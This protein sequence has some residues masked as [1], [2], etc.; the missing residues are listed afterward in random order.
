MSLRGIK[1]SMSRFLSIVSIV[2]LGVGFLAGL[3]A[4][5]PDMKNSANKYFENSNLYDFYIQ[6]DIGFDEEDLK[7]IEKQSYVDKAMAVYQEDLIINDNNEEKLEARVFH[8]DMRKKNVINKVD[9]IDGRMPENENECLIEIPNKYGLKGELDETYEFPNEEKYKVVGIVRSPMFISSHSE[10]TNIGKGTITLGIYILPDKENKIFTTIYGRGNIKDR[11]TFKEEYK[12]DVSKIVT[13]LKT[14]ENSMI[15]E[16]YARIGRKTD[17]KEETIDYGKWHIFTRFNS[18]GIK[19]FS[20][21][22]E[23][24]EAIATVF[25]I[26]FF[27]VAALIVLT[28]MTRM[29]EEERTQVGVLKALGYTNGVIRN[30]YIIYGLIA[31]IIGSAIGLSVGF[32]LFPKVISNAYS[33]MY[34]LPKID[35]EFLWIIAI[36]IVISTLICVMS[37]IL[38]ACK[39]ELKEKPASLLQQKAPIPGKRIFLEKI[40]PLWKRLKFTRKVTL[41]NLFRYKKRF[42]MTVVGIAGCFSLL[43]AGFGVRDSI[44]NIDDLQFG[45]IFKHDIMISVKENKWKPDNK[46]FEE[47][48]T[49]FEKQIEVSNKDVK[50]KVT[51]EVPKE[52]ENLIDFV[53]LRERESKKPLVLRDDGV[54][55][56]EKVSE[57]LDIRVGD[58]VWIYNEDMKKAQVEVK[59]IFENYLDNKVFMTEDLYKKTFRET[60]GYNVVYAKLKKEITAKTE[61]DDIL[62]TIVKKTDVNYTIATKNIRN[63]FNDS[64]KNIDYIVMV[65]ILSSGS[66][67]IIVLYNL[68]NINIC[69]RKKELATIKVLGFYDKEVAA[70]IFREIHILTTIGIIIGIPAGI[71]LHK[72]II[73]TAEVGG[74]MFGRDIYWQSFVLAVVTTLLFAGFVNIIMRRSIMKIDMVESMKANE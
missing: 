18:I 48:M 33:M 6:S 13:N 25:P 46:L 63:N 3:L 9:L 55:I 16:R 42:I 54:I 66:L 23:K 45:E 21:D 69:E 22:V 7:K 51:L 71:I 72:F 12:D 40:T 65:L 70:Y 5:A 35:V 52:S 19:S 34:N 27:F 58:K 31:T 26:F 20:E 44:G 10:N 2:A 29:I 56:S 17:I 39:G 4:T 53:K 8:I 68:T 11:D 14:I 15:K 37:T 43:L 24:V 47:E 67:S 1:K 61:L 59:G 49:F 36:I 57:I 62:S 41:R 38:F 60:P 32:T 73:R 64:V 30:Y 74:M 50:E 28:T